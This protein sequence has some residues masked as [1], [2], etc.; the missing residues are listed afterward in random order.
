MSRYKFTPEI[1]AEIIRRFP[2]ENTQQLANDIGCGVRTLYGKVRDLKLH[3]T[4]EFIAEWYALKSKL[5]SAA[6]SQN[7]PNNRPIGTIHK[8]CNGLSIIKTGA[9]KWPFLKHVR[10]EEKNGKIPSGC[11]LICK[12]Q[13]Y[14]NT[15]PDNWECIT[16]KE[17][18]MKNSVRNL[19]P[20]L[21]EICRLKGQLKR[22]INER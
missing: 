22:K 2:H 18:L 14:V 15:N 11:V 6:D 19:P 4:K 21:I 5:M 3:K 12:S 9:R 20:E 17:L 10:W 13:N 16:R 7:T 1:V 8:D